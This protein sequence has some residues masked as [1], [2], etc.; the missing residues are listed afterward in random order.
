MINSKNVENYYF[1]N[2]SIGKLTE[3]APKIRKHKDDYL[4]YLVDHYFSGQKTFPGLAS[5]DK[6]IFVDSTNEPTT[7]G[8]DE[9]CQSV[10]REFSRLPAAIIAIGGGCTLDTCKAVANLMTNG[11]H[12]E[13]YQGWDLVKVPGVYTIGVPTISG[14]GAESSRTCVLINHKKSLKLGMNS[15]FSVFKQLILDPDLSKSV[16]RNQYFYTG[17]DTYIHCVESL[18]GRHRHAMADAFSRESLHLCEQVFSTGDMQSEANREKLMTASYLGGCAIANSFVGLVHPLSAGLSTVLGTHHGLANCLVMN[19]MQEFYPDACATFKK[20]LSVQKVSLPENIC[21]NFTDEQFEQLYQS[22][23]VHRKPLA[24]ALGEDFE[25]I[26]TKAK[27]REI[28][29]RI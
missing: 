14:T 6:L 28:F 24:N 4:L 18:E 16:P 7:E 27:A 19:Q 26:L 11:G 3:L 1:G 8:I 25:R 20:M 10:M 15:Q 9:I 2:G 5:T 21:K 12:A 29:Q 17:M 22:S 23:I 13:D